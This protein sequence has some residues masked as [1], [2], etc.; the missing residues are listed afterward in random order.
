[1]MC[2]GQASVERERMTVEKMWA[3][4]LTLD[5]YNYNWTSKSRDI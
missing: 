5:L 4:A 1:M 3:V 2:G